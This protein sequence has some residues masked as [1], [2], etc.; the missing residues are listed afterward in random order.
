MENKFENIFVI[1]SNVIEKNNKFLL[2]RETKKSALG[3]YNLPAG[4]LEGNETIIEAAIREAKEE[5]G[6][7]VKP[8]KII[9]IYQR[10]NKNGANITIFVFK[11]KIISGELTSSQE[12]P[13]RSNF[14]TREEIAN[15]NKK[16]LIRTPY[17][18]KAIQKY[19]DNE[20][21]DLSVLKV[22]E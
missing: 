11:S 12:H 15:L 8:D 16:G 20:F 2:V 18:T 17:I 3:L 9:G 7:N 14:F 5:T 10:P 6:L 19:L 13:E 21:S 1:A 4:K 22:V